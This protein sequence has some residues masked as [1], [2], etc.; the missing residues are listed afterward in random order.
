MRLVSQLPSLSSV[1]KIQG[2]PSGQRARHVPD[3]TG[4]RRITDANA[5]PR[6]ANVSVEYA[7]SVKWKAD[8][9]RRVSAS[10]VDTNV[11]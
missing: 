9:T 11:R 10:T 6:G 1:K 2:S 5:S 4:Y 8:L 7:P 3:Y